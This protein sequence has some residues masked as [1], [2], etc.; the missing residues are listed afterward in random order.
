VVGWPEEDLD[1]LSGVHGLVAGGQLVEGE[2]EVEDLA[3]VDPTVPD[4][5]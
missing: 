3:Q 2:F 4:Q 1:R 5:V